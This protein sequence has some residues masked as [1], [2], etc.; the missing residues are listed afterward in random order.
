MM[1]VRKYNKIIGNHMS[2][3]IVQQIK[4]LCDT[5]LGLC[6][7]NGTLYDFVAISSQ[8]ID[9]FVNNVIIPKV[10]QSC[11]Y[12]NKLILLIKINKIQKYWQCYLQK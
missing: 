5:R 11:I 7:K 3:F 4:N 2:L 10:N 1:Q 6:K 9:T 8:E 12:E